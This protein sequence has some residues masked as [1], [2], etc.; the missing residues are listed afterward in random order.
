M[1]EFKNGIC[2]CVLSGGGA[3]AADQSNYCKDIVVYLA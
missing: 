3:Y 1:S 2:G